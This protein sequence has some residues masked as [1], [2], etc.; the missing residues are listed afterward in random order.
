[1]KIIYP[2]AFEEEI[3][4]RDDP[5]R[6]S[7]GC[8]I[9]CPTLPDCV[10]TGKNEQCVQVLTTCDKCA[11]NNCIPKTNNGKSTNTGGI[12]GGV[13]GGLAVL[14]V[15]GATLY[16]FLIYKKKHQVMLDDDYLDYD[17][18]DYETDEYI[19][20]GSDI[21]NNNNGSKIEM[22]ELG[23]LSDPSSPASKSF[24]LDINESPSSATLANNNNDVINANTGTNNG[25]AIIAGQHIDRP[26]QQRRIL[27]NNPRKTV[28][29]ISSYESFTRPNAN[30]SKTKQ[31]QQLI[32]QQRRARQ[33]KIVKQA[34]LQQQQIQPP[35]QQQQ[36]YLNQSNRNSVATS[37]S[38]ASNILPIAYV[39]GVTVRPTKNNTRSI[40]SY[41]SD[42]IFS[43]LNTIENASIVGDVII[44]NQ[45]STSSSNNNGTEKNDSPQSLQS[46]QSNRSGTMT[47]IKA[48][49][50]LVNVDRI[51]EEDE[52]EDEDDDEE[53]DDDE[54]EE[55]Y[56][57]NETTEEDET[58]INTED[59]NISK[60]E[61][62]KKDIDEEDE[63]SDVDSDVGHITRAASLKKQESFTFDIEFNENPLPITHK[64]NNNDNDLNSVD[65]PFRDP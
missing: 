53:E 44:A 14:G 41:D 47:A 48:Q 56:K 10:C 32:A 59:Y 29:R 11:Y 62:L 58:R 21:N 13:I 33:Q 34:N 15:I 23:D 27:Q 36:I 17:Y 31:Q 20:K 51:Q 37:F 8:V 55:D 22:K 39:P 18:N 45:L 9:N 38:N 57:L 28:R 43:D 7:N 64:I 35:P 2:N 52:D 50:R 46:D 54:D 4:I 16:Y 63:D 30:K 42:S 12:V 1:M 65:S 6:D 49:P 3:Y 25:G 19:D 5:Q 61:I 24:G 60:D 40:Y 26:L